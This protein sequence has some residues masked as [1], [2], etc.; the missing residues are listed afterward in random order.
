M[1]A[2]PPKADMCDALVDVRFGPEADIH[3]FAPKK[4]NPKH[5]PRLFINSNLSW[6]L[7]AEFIADT[8]ED[9][10]NA[11][12]DVEGVA[13]RAATHLVVRRSHI[14]V[15]VL[16]TDDPIGREPIFQAGTGRPAT[17]PLRT[18]SSPHRGTADA[19]RVR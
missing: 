14:D 12:F 2:L 11:S 19:T 10:L 13:A 17:L 9:C 6:V 4:K 18:A 7:L 5:C 1:S 8:C 3:E 15:G 16:C